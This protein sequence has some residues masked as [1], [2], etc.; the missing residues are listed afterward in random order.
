MGV[1][2]TGNGRWVAIALTMAVDIVIVLILW[3]WYKF[4][5]GIGESITG[6]PYS[7][8][9][10]L[11][12][13]VG[14][15]FA[16]LVGSWIK[17]FTVW[18]IKSAM[19][20]T[21][22]HPE[23]SFV[24]T[25]QGVMAHGASTVSVPIANKIVRSS[26]NALFASTDNVFSLESHFPLLEKLKNSNF[27]KVTAWVYN[28]VAEFV[29]ECVLAYCYA[30]EAGEF[31]KNAVKGIAC[32]VK[33]AP[34]MIATIISFS[35]VRGI[36]DF[37]VIVI[38]IRIAT[39]SLGLGWT[40]WLTVYVLAWCCVWIV[41]D[42]IVNNVLLSLIVTQYMD[43]LESDL[44][45]VFSEDAEFSNDASDSGVT[46]STSDSDGTDTMLDSDEEPKEGTESSDSLMNEVTQL[47]EKYPVLE[48]IL[49]LDKN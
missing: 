33:V 15:M 43:K 48:D 7:F 12:G 14:V 31:G 25:I 36:V 47:I 46:D 11:Y 34:K 22:V 6:M 20:Y 37:G 19:I 35:A 4:T 30:S 44:G 42:S 9:D 24:A 32:F 18:M 10:P 41:N 3:K 38:T 27:M 16:F 28:S 13:G 26:I 21:I 5:I 40:D 49:H 2:T 45:I 8:L 39:S 29:D 17:P 1:R 23:A